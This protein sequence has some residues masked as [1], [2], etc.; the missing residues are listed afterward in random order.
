MRPLALASV[1][2]VTL[3][4]VAQ[5]Q[6]SAATGDKAPAISN[7]TRDST[8]RQNGANDVR[9]RTCYTLR[10]YLFEPSDGG[11]RPT[12]SITCTPAE[13]FRAMYIPTLPSSDTHSALV[14]GRDSR[15]YPAVLKGNK[16]PR[17]DLIQH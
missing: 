2:L 6:P 1:L 12:G 4:A 7:E 3:G 17:S 9:A 13:K 8:T 11:V 16:A 10:T 15:A 5:N 14:T